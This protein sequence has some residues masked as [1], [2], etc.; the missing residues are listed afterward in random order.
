[1][2]N[3]KKIPKNN[4]YLIVVL[5]IIACVLIATGL[6]VGLSISH[7]AYA[8]S[9]PVTETPAANSIIPKGGSITIKTNN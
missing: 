2:L 5:S 4:Y 6:P 8:H 3:H 7:Y 9:L 1:M